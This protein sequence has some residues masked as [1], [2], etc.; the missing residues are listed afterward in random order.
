MLI[1]AD[2]KITFCK[3]KFDGSKDCDSPNF[4][5]IWNT[6][7]PRGLKEDFCKNCTIWYQLDIAP[8]SEF[9]QYQASFLEDKIYSVLID[10]SIE[11]G[12]D[13]FEKEDYEKALD[14]WEKV[15]RFD[16]SNE[17]IHRKLDELLEQLKDKE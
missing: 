14:E 11:N 5:E 16:P 17:F 8:F 3:Q 6:F 13:L 9:S 10:Q 15:L 1:L 7:R 4:L 2:G 12:K